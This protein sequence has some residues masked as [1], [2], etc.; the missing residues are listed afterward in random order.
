MR[1]VDKVVEDFDAKVR[2]VL[3]AKATYESGL[4]EL[5]GMLPAVRQALRSD[6]SVPLR[7]SGPKAIEQR[8]MNLIPR[9]TISD[10]TAD[11]M[12]TRREGQPAES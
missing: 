6:P 5:K 7:Q 10:L 2:Q 9:E 4:A 12:G 3:R 1:G 11:A 8:A